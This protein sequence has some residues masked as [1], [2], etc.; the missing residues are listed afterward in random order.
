MGSIAKAYFFWVV[1]THCQVQGAKKKNGV[2]T[3]ANS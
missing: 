1:T 3:P 2:E